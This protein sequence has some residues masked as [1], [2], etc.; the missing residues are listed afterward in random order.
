MEFR[1]YAVYYTPPDGA[2]ARF[3]ARWLGWDITTGRPVR[4]TPP[5]DLPAPLDE[6]TETPRKYGFHATIKPPFRLAPG[7]DPE[8][9]AQAVARLCTRTAPVTLDGLAPAPLGGFLALR[10]TGDT[11]ALDRLAATVVEELDT[12]RA[13]LTEDERARRRAGGLTPRQDALLAMWGY[14]H[15]MEAFRFHM[16]LTGRLPGAQRQQVQK[17]LERELRPLLPAPF[18]VD[19][20]SLVGEAGDGRFHLVHRHALS[21]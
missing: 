17:V 12:F 5:E 8:A 3:G 4:Q 15:V 21:S 9:L 19:G 14:P 18:V 6:I 2:L 1:R 7:Q 13:P 11:A 20:L 10:P 16:T